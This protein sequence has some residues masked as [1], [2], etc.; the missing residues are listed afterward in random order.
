[1]AEMNNP[2]L[3]GTVQH[4]EGN[5]WLR[6]PDGK[7][8]VL[9]VGDHINP[10]D[11]IVTDHNAHVEL[12]RPNGAVLD[13]G[14]DRTLLADQD[15]L[16]Q[17]APDRSEAAILP[18]GTD[19][20]R[21]IAALNAGQDPF[22]IV[23][24]AEAG[25]IAGGQDSGHGFVRLL[26][27]TEGVTATTFD[28]TSGSTQT[29]LLPP[30]GADPVLQ[31]QALTPTPPPAPDSLVLSTS[32]GTISEGGSIVYTVSAGAPVSGTPLVITLSSGTTITIPVGASSASSTPVPVRSDDVY[33]EGPQS[34]TA[35]ITSATGGTF[36]T[37]EAGSP[38]TTV[39]NDDVDTTT[40]TLAATPSATEGGNIV[41][42]A[43]LS[44]PAATPVTVALSN[45]AHITIATGAVSGTVTVAAPADDVYVNSVPVT[46]AIVSTSGGGFENLVPDTTPAS[47]TINDTVNTTTVT[48]SAPAS[49]IEGGTITYSA[50]VDHAVTG[51]PLV[52]T[53]SNGTTIT[54]PVGSSTGTSA[55]IVA[56]TDDVYTQ[57]STAVPVS[58]TSHTGG[59]F[60]ALD[61]SST[62]TTSVTD[63]SDATT[64]SLSATPTV[65][66]GGSITYTATLT[67]A[68]ASPVTVTLNN[69]A[70]ITIAAGALTGNVAVAA[71]GDDVYVDAAPV[72]AA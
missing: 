45:G 53:L 66:E 8:I 20:D 1:M 38:V 18:L 61:T 72:S 40:V 68:A 5:A 46:T 2:Q 28:A 15:V 12:A 37:Y 21:V 48:L 52:L 63:D 67:S 25:L 39:V 29:E 49:A 23:D 41:Y 30:H 11:V 31:Q 6:L 14:P 60:E 32:G 13:I 24:P 65:A 26:R 42:T 35:S 69:G 10:G 62:A 56:R 3:Q 16:S 19:A 51:S 50:S 33:I 34:I 57:G 44:N 17:S 71:P 27:I 47:T 54:I 4:I 55:P 70:V 36:S 43:T 22:A 7:M 9:K 59:N 58:I 64:V